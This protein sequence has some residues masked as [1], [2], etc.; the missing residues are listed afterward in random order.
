MNLK[1]A[2]SSMTVTQLAKQELVAENT[3]D[4]VKRLKTKLKELQSAKVIVKNIEREIE[5]L[6]QEIEQEVADINA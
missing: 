3:K 4:A 2:G 6:E 5:D 1:V